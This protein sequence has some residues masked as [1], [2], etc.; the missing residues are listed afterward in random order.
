MRKRSSQSALRALAGALECS[1][2]RLPVDSE[3]ASH[4]IGLAWRGFLG[5]EGWRSVLQEVPPVGA[6]LAFFFGAAAL[7]LALVLALVLVF[8]AFGAAVFALA[9]VFAAFGAAVAVAVAFVF[10]FVLTLGAAAAFAAFTGAFA[11][12]LL[13]DFFTAMMS[14]PSERGNPEDR[15]VRNGTIGDVSRPSAR[16]QNLL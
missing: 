16:D 8:A 6:A 2:R 13:A 10:A 14:D 3:E 12:G 4:R 11:F 7:A 9:L 5:A 15:S 1:E